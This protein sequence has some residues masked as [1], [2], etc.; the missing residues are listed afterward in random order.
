MEKYLK[1]LDEIKWE[2]S[3]TTNLEFMAVDDMLQRFEQF[4]L[5]LIFLIK[6]V[7]EAFEDKALSFDERWQVHDM[8]RSLADE[9]LSNIID[10]EKIEEGF[11]KFRSHN[12]V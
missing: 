10:E 11:Q 4:D 7:E 2:L 8:A 9:F 3:E 6:L 1:E 5:E 12:E